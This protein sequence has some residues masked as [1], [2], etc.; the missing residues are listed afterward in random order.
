MPTMAASFDTGPPL[1]AP[2]GRG[3]AGVVMQGDTITIHI[4]V[5]AGADAQGIARAVG[6]ELDRRDAA[7]R[8]RARGSFM[9]YDN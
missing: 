5:P 7:R 4:N 1:S 8:A 3:G 2:A 9:D 6:A